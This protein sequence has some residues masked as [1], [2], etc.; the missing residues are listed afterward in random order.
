MSRSNGLVPYWPNMRFFN[1]ASDSFSNG[2]PTR[3]MSA[4]PTKCFVTLSIHHKAST[5][6]D[7]LVVG[8]LKHTVWSSLEPHMNIFEPSQYSITFRVH[9]TVKSLHITYIAC[10]WSI[11]HHINCSPD[12]MSMPVRRHCV[13]SEKIYTFFRKSTFSD[14]SQP[15]VGAVASNLPQSL[16]IVLPTAYQAFSW[17]RVDARERI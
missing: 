3:N 11:Q 4:R 14:S 9:D 8:H 7:A 1:M 16:H 10:M 15:Q 2:L 12:G 6:C 17:W 5:D 13:T